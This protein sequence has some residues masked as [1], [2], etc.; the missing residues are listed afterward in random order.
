MDIDISYWLLVD[1]ESHTRPNDI[2]D[3]INQGWQ[4]L[5]HSPTQQFVTSTNSQVISSRI[6][7]LMFAAI[8]TFYKLKLE[9][10]FCGQGNINSNINDIEEALMR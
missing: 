2:T 4:Y 3:G 6:P 8:L 10:H 9:W 5:A 1:Y 7:Q